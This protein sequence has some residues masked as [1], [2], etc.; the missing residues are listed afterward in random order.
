[1]TSA[2]ALPVQDL[3][4]RER[5]AIAVQP[6]ICLRCGQ[7]GVRSRWEQCVDTLRNE[8]AMLTLGRGRQPRVARKRRRRGPPSRSEGHPDSIGTARIPSPAPRSSPADKN[9][10]LAS[11]MEE[12]GCAGE[13]GM[14]PEAL[15]D[16]TKRSRQPKYQDHAPF[17]FQWESGISLVEGPSPFG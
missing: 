15:G 8:I 2:S 4:D 3:L 5:D 16:L 17:S 12:E 13:P 6:G 14:Q 7:S 1:M 9:S 11:T 10:G